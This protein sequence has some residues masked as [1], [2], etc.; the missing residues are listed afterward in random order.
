VFA[1]VSA[2][3][4]EKSGP[5]PVVTRFPGWLTVSW[6][7]AQNVNEHSIAP[8]YGIHGEGNRKSSSG[9]EQ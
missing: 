6:I 8:L 5:R 7:F 9:V 4:S 3:R 2:R 1:K